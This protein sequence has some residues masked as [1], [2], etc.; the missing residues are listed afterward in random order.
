MK[1][2]APCVDRILIK[3]IKINWKIKDGYQNG[4]MTKGHFPSCTV[5]DCFE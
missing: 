1:R 4:L 5:A 3:F 2:R